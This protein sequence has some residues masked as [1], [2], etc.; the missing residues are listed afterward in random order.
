MMHLELD[1][2]ERNALAETLDTD[3]SG[4]TDEISHTDTRDYREFLK[5]RREV[6][7]K[8]RGMLH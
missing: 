7:E 1:E 4:L 8:I 5:K 6:L 2:E 3:L